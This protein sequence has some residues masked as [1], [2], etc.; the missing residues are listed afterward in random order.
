[1]FGVSNEVSYW[2]YLTVVLNFGSF[3]CERSVLEP[4][5]VELEAEVA[6]RPHGRVRCALKRKTNA[7]DFRPCMRACFC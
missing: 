2:R 3:V 7:Y 6:L 5:R 1:M 4:V